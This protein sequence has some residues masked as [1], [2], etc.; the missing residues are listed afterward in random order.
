MD[1]NTLD[2]YHSNRQN[3]W[4]LPKLPNNLTLED[5]ANWILNQPIGWLKLNLQFELDKWK[6][7]CLNLGNVFVEHRDSESKGW[8]SCCI[9]GLGPNLT[10]T[11][12]NYGY[13][14]E[15]TAPY[16]WTELAK[17][18]PTITEF[19]KNI[20]CQQFK[21][22]RIMLLEPG[23]YIAPHLDYNK[24]S[25]IDFLSYGVPLNIAVIHPKECFMTFEK[26]GELPF[27]EGQ[28]YIPNITYK[29]SFINLSNEP[30]IHII[31]DLIVGNQRQKFSQLVID[32][33]L[34]SLD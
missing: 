25:D 31:A 32:S 23:G 19:F 30:R 3:I 29:H 8:K 1:Q 16:H 12:P 24:T 15:L 27:S 11:S 28:C 7:E 22:I 10:E 33:Y 4:S 14:N 6:T 34:A 2:F 18:T 9:H 20:P 13:P 21:R 5:T 26:F 17:L